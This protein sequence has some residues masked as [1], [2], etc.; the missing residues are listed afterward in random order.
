[1]TTKNLQKKRVQLRLRI[2]SPITIFLM[3]IL[4]I[5]I[6]ILIA[7][8]DYLYLGSPYSWMYVEFSIFF[9]F[10]GLIFG[11]G[12]IRLKST[13]ISVNINIET[14]KNIFII[15]SLLASFGVILRILDKYYIRGASISANMME[16]RD[17]LAEASLNAFSVT[18]SFFYPL[19]LLL[20]FLY[21]LLR[22]VN[23]HN[24]FYFLAL[25]LLSLF[26]IV[27]GILFGSRS[28]IMIWLFLILMYLSV[29]GFFEFKMISKKALLVPVLL[30]LFFIL[31]GYMFDHRT[32]LMGM[33][34]SE[35][36]QISVYAYFLP[37]KDSYVTLLQ[38]N[39]GNLIYFFILGIL[40][41]IQ[42]MT[43][44][45]FELL[46]LVD[47]FTSDKMLLGEQNFAIIVKFIYKILQIPFSF[48]DNSE[49]LV[50]TGIYNT[51]FGPIY[52]DFAFFGIGFSL[53]LGLLIGFIS[54]KVMNGDIFLYPLY[55]YF[56]LL[57]FFSLV[58]NMIIFG[59][60]LYNMV[61]FSIF[62]F[63]SKFLY[64]P[65]KI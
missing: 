11:M 36:T 34:P 22:K 18:S 60:G 17:I 35:S 20:P 37:L 24:I 43:H 2:I 65:K 59:Q 6:L 48:A 44:G 56:L 30:I 10:I 52:Y 40:N 61:A 32:S 25:V 28:V 51:L 50:R 8:V 26:P 39:E 27:D 5:G 21:L 16:N 49:I 57:L 63:L 1:M 4:F 9:L 23:A 62:Y 46:Y 53:I 58:V 29:F 13:V 55:L 12:G 33:E 31:N 42:Y 19:V 14:L 41:F 54:K 45:L 38:S 47:N 64:L 3:G 7:P 15:A